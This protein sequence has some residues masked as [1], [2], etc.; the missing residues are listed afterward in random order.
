[1]NRNC[2][3][4]FLVLFL[5]NFLFGQTEFN[6]KLYDENKIYSKVEI[7]N[8]FP[9]EREL[10]QAEILARYGYIFE[11]TL[12]Q[13]YFLKQIWYKP[14]SNQFPSL[15]EN[16]FKNYQLFETYNRVNE[17][18]IW[19]NIKKF[20]P[21]L[22]DV[23]K[24]YFSYCFENSTYRSIAKRK[25]KLKPFN[26]CYRQVFYVPRLELPVGVWDFERFFVKADFNINDYII[27]KSANDVRGIIFRGY[28]S[29][30]GRLLQMDEVGVDPGINL[31]EL[32]TENYLDEKGRIFVHYNKYCNEG[33]FKEMARYLD[34]DDNSIKKEILFI[35]DDDYLYF[36]I[37]TKDYFIETGLRKKK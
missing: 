22:D 8:L 18:T 3:I 7:E 34:Y 20:K 31:G 21:T 19:E 23:T 4:F 29:K 13:R 37:S 17:R 12:L 5:F 35:E 25:F 10:I 6:V 36:Q 11:D 15:S 14:K 26:Y 2:F 28:F 33:N 24:S 1:M 32:V 16:D 9:I 30:N 27:F